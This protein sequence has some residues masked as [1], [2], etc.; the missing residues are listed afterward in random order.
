MDRVPG[1]FLD[2]LMSSLA[3]ATAGEVPAGAPV[4]AKAEVRE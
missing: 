4:I 3:G 2:N 1:S